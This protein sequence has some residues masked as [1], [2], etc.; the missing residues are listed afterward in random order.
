MFEVCK[1]SK[2]RN[3]SSLVLALISNVTA[4]KKSPK[5]AVS[6][7]DKWGETYFV[8]YRSEAKFDSAALTLERI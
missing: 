5:A 7:K 8:E 6:L 1:S 3:G 2:E 4:L